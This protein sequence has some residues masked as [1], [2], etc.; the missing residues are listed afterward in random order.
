M[1]WLSSRSN[2]N[3]TEVP[4]KIS[5]T[6]AT[7]DQGGK[8]TGPTSTTATVKIPINSPNP[9]LPETVNYVSIAK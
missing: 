2:D 4:N 5:T 8:R 9:M 6:R 1:S 7:A 3:N